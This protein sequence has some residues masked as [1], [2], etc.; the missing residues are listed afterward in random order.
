MIVKN[1][2]PLHLTISINVLT[3]CGC[4]LIKVHGRT[5]KKGNKL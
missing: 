3:A 4:P 5:K 1:A 2:V